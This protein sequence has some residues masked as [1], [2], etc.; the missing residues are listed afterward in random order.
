MEYQ[1]VFLFGNE[2]KIKTE[3]LFLFL[4]YFNSSE[5]RAQPL[6]KFIY[7]LFSSF[8]VQP[9]PSQ[10]ILVGQARVRAEICLIICL[11]KRQHAA[12]FVS[13]LP[14]NLQSA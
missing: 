1:I 2:R 6:Y 5:Q 9:E 7:V 13:G 4:F 3:F 14:Q 10:Q 11:I 8:Q 12:A